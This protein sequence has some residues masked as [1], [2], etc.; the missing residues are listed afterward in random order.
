MEDAP[1][2]VLILL[3]ADLSTDI[4]RGREPNQ[5]AVHRGR[6]TF[7]SFCWQPKRDYTGMLLSS[8]ETLFLLPAERP[9]IVV[10]VLYLC[11]IAA[12]LARL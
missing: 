6:H 12:V 7:I 8:C 3:T 11:S 10:G 2:Q 9:G 4:L 5:P 1:P